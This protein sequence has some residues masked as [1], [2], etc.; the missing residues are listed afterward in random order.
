MSANLDIYL[1]FPS[2]GLHLAR[3]FKLLEVI[4]HK[5][6][7]GRPR[8]EIPPGC[9]P[10]VLEITRCRIAQLDEFTERMVGRFEL[11]V[12]PATDIPP[13]T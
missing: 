5:I 6:A 12:Q 13:V 9:M 4:L 8:F 11:F 10:G 3:P 1:G 2:A 7:K